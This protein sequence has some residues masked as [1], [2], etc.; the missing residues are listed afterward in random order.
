MTKEKLASNP[1]PVSEK[2]SF[3]IIHNC[4]FNN[5]DKSIYKPISEKSEVEDSE[6]L[7]IPDK[8]SISEKHSKISNK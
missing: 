6:N 1:L 8:I 3:I 5:F 4:G 2:N 7:P